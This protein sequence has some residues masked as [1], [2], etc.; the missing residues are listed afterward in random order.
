MTGEMNV[1]EFENPPKEKIDN[2]T[3]EMNVF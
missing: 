2:G 3:G 1:Y